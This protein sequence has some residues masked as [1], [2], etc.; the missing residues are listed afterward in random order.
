M[1]INKIG[2]P[3]N[4]NQYK[5]N[6][7]SHTTNSDGCLT[8]EEAV[9]LY[10]KNNYHF[11]CLSE[12]DKY[13]DYRNEFN[14]ENFIILPGLEASATL[15]V[16]NNSSRRVKTHHI[17]GILGSRNMQKN[18]KKLFSHMEY[19]TP[20]LYYDNWDGHTVAQNLVNELLEHGCLTTYNHP[21]WSRVELKEFQYVENVWG[22]EIYNYNTVNESGT[23]YDVTYWDCILRTGKQI[24]GVASDDNH[25]EGLFDDACGG[26]IQVF[27][28]SLTHDS[29]IEAMLKGDFY[30]SSGPK[31]YAYEIKNNVVHIECSPCKRINFI[32]GGDINVG[33]TQI[34]KQNEYISHAEYILKGSET[35]VRVE[36]I[37]Y[38]NNI[39]WT[40]AIFINES[41]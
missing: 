8:P 24:Y 22:L 13:T 23:G 4:K 26:W 34:A 25:N 12:H 35:Y 32:C 39:A 41:L 27:A 17:H 5:G 6:L 2:L 11:L 18:A 1:N 33:I 15:Y 30:S 14:D 40:N 28:D 3:Q 7:H 29:I 16:K 36:C 38:N 10:K 31:I 19:L 37:D 21:V 20:N 9:L